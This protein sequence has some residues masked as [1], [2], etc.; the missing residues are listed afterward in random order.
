MHAVFD[1]HRGGVELICEERSDPG[2]LQGSE[3][4]RLTHRELAVLLEVEK[5]K[6]NH[7]IAADLGIQP[8]TVEKHLEHIFDKLN[9]DNRMAAV[10]CLRRTHVQR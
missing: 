4:L 2:S 7:R 5:G 3:D 8:R 9:V 6:H 10:A 1:I